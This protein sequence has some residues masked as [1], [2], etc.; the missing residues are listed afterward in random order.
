MGIKSQYLIDL[1][2]AKFSRPSTMFHGTSSVFLRK[3][4]KMGLVPSPSERR[5]GEESGNWNSPSLESYPGVYFAE[6]VH[7]AFSSSFNT[8]YKFGGNSVIVVASIQQRSGLPDEDSV[9]KYLDSNTLQNDQ[10]VKNLFLSLFT[11]DP[12]YKNDSLVYSQ[13][14]KWLDNLS[15]SLE[16]DLKH[17]SDATFQLFRAFVA[18][19]FSYYKNIVHYLSPEIENRIP[20]KE[21]AERFFRRVF[22]VFLIKIKRLAVNRNMDKSDHTLRVTGPVT[23]RGQNRILSIYEDI[24]IEED[25]RIGQVVFKVHYG[26]PMTEFERGYRRVNRSGKIRYV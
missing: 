8:V 9:I 4:L 17:S 26:K 3:I 22:D 25:R 18:R 10:V 24:T 5:W 23:Y 2:E 13:Y 12:K 1:F 11:N 15:Y 14:L 7:R 19:R 16:M 6:E 21:E 20:S